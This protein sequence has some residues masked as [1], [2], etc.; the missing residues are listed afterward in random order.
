MD[1][2][3]APGVSVDPVVVDVGNERLSFVGV[4]DA[5]TGASSIPF[6]VSVRVGGTWG[7]PAPPSLVAAVAMD[8]G[9]G[10]G[11]NS[12]DAFVLV[13]PGYFFV[14]RGGICMLAD[15]SPPQLLNQ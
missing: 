1:G 8:T 6:D 4:G 2:M 13:S 15:T 5:A 3:L 11:L 7:V 10:V 14:D 12:G 9:R